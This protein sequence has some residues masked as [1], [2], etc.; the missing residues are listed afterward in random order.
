M[1]HVGLVE[2]MM[3]DR[4]LAVAHVDEGGLRQRREQLVG[5]MRREDRRP[6]V[7]R[8]VAAHREVVP[9]HRVE[10]RIAVPRLVEVDP[11]AGFRE[12]RLGA[13]GVVA[14][15]V[16]GAVGDDRVDRLLVGDR[17]RERARLRLRADRLGIHLR[18]RDRADD[19]VAVARR[20]H[21]DRPRAGQHQALLD[22][23]VA[24]AVEDD[25]V[26]LLHAGLHDAAVRARCADDARIAAMGAE[27]AR[28]IL[29]ALGDR[30]GMVEQRAERAALDAHVDAKHV[31]A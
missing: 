12:Q 20:H 21:V 13:H 27:H 18:R 4:A 16:V 15:A 31:L 1:H 5:G 22:R 10:A 25:Q 17:L 6:V 26:V 3:I 28:G 23:L 29:L 2:A 30:S 19:A 8:R 11:V 7:R 24:V 9:V 14:Q